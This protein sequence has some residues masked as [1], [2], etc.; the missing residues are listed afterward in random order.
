LPLL[1]FLALPWF[2]GPST[3]VSVLIFYLTWSGLVA[4]HD[5][6]T[7]EIGGTLLVRLLCYVLPA[8]AF[9]AFDCF[10]PGVSR[11]IKARG[12][13]Q[14]PLRQVGPNGL[15]KVVTVSVG[16]VLLSVTLQGALELLTTHSLHLRSLLRVTALVP[17]P[18]SLLKDVATGLIIRGFLR[19]GIHRYFLHTLDTPLKSWHSQWQH[20]VELP[21]SLVASY[22]HPV[23]YLVSEWMPAFLPAYLFRFH[24]LAWHAL[25]AIASIEELF[26]YSGYVILPSAIL[27]PG[28]ARR[29]EAHFE[30]ARSNKLVGNFGHLGLI[31]FMFGTACEDENDVVDDLQDEAERHRLQQR[32]GAASVG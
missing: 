10:T 23:N 5:P 22:D 30:S 13:R 12:R 1:S 3:A 4:S 20:S 27:L 7:L 8:L 6:L 28:M 2:G 16:N 25:L 31:D 17:L 19:Y 9:L 21:F 15:A 18:W 29:N 11:K 26:V 24:I 14:L 32:A